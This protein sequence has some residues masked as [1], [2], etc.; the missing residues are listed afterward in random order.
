[1][2]NDL[3]SRQAAIDLIKNHS[4]PVRY[5]RNSIEQGMTLTGIEQA[6]KEVPSIQLEQKTGHWLA[7]DEDTWECSECKDLFTTL[8]GTPK[9]NN[10]H[11][12]PNCGAFMKG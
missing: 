1:M 12:C 2:S 7:F 9:D 5:D 8:D 10:F 11:Y 4:Y 6:L 3:I